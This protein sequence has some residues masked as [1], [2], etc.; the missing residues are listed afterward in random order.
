MHIVSG[1]NLG[2]HQ[3]TL[4]KVK[5]RRSKVKNRLFPEPVL[6]EMKYS[7]Q[8]ATV[9]QKKI[10]LL[11]TEHLSQIPNLKFSPLSFLNFGH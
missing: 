11:K 2:T 7:E 5:S 8:R 9:L 4:S 10:P 3:K 1:R 6:K